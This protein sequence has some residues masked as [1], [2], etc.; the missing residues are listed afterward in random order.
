VTAVRVPQ[1]IDSKE[2][3][4]RLRTQHGVVLS[5]GQGPLEKAIFRIGHMGYVQQEQLLAALDALR[6]VLSELGY[7]VKKGTAVQAAARD[8]SRG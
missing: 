1:G 4:R 7:S 5:G 8:P 2:M 3:L 6:L